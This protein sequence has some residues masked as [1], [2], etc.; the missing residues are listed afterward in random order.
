[1]SHKDKRRAPRFPVQDTLPVNDIITESNLGHIG[2]LSSNG[3]MLIT[4]HEPHDE[5][6]YQLQTYLP[7]PSGG[8]GRQVQFG[9][10]EQWHEPAGV[11][12][13]YWAGFRIIAI[14]PVDARALDAWL[15][16]NEAA[17]TD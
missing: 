12:G 5:A 6:I 3:M 15:T 7:G 8:P 1:M 16:A 14:D 4:R 17:I 2:N 10:Q 9:V 11:P 13:Q